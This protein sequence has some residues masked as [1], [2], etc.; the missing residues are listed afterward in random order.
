MGEAATFEAGTGLYKVED[1][2][3]PHIEF[4]QTINGHVFEQ[5]FKTHYKNLFVY[6][7][8]IL[9][10]QLTAEETVQNV[11]FKLWE[12]KSSIPPGEQ[13][14]PY[15]YRAV[16]NECLNYIKHEKVKHRY[17]LHIA[18]TDRGTEQPASSKATTAELEKEIRQALDELPE[19][20]RT[21]FQLSRFE[22]M[23]YKQIAGEL[24]ISVKTV[25]NQMGKALKFLRARL[26][27]FLPLLLLINHLF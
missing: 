2:G 18:E 3:K 21:I 9:K 23:K 15:L 12:K 16:H 25:E 17:K 14:K 10:N 20:C 13:L 6:A 7:F 1:T 22:D 11:F 4:V 8:T 5:V 19:Q 27:E 26:A 24:N